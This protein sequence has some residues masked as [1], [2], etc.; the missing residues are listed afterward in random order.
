M[1]AHESCVFSLRNI[2]AFIDNVAHA[3]L[4]VTSDDT[5]TTDSCSL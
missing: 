4:Y 5:T 2:T 3:L 1:Y